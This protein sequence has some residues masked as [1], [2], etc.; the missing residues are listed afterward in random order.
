[1]CAILGQIDQTMSL[2]STRKCDVV[3]R[4]L[5]GYN[6]RWAK[7][8]LPRLISKDSA[9]SNHIAAVTVF[10]GANDCALEGRESA[11]C[12]SL[13]KCWAGTK[14]CTPFVFLRTR[15]DEHCS[16]RFY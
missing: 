12:Y 16:C 9:S 8:V 1:M 2:L 6:S 10:F 3:N 15:I 5:S 14:P 7:I 11:T 13:A 4:G